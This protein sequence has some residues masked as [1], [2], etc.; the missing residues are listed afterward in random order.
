MR[1]GVGRCKEIA[2][3]IFWLELSL[4]VVRFSVMLDMLAVERAMLEASALSLST[5]G[6]RV[7]L[8]PIR[9]SLIV[10]EISEKKYC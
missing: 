2:A 3:M 1:V 6:R 7:P 8:A 4:F 10:V 5:V 9:R